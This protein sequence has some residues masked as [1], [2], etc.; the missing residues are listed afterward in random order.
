MKIEEAYF[1]TLSEMV[2]LCGLHSEMSDEQIVTT[3]E[4]VNAWLFE[5][6]PD[7]VERYKVYL[8]KSIEREK[9]RGAYARA[10][11]LN[12]QAMVLS[13]FEDQA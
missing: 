7:V 5:L 1:E 2:I 8:K 10:K 4:T 13:Y 11:V 3:N 6:P 9:A 12:D